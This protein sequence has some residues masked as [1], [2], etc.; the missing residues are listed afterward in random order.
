MSLRSLPHLFEPER[1]LWVGREGPAP[2]WI[3]IAEANLWGAG[4]KG[5]IQA[6]RS[7]GRAPAEACLETF[8]GLSG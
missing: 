4:F 5:P 3:Q 1:I 7:T 8:A 2:R 6:M